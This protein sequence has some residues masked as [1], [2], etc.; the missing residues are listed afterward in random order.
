MSI[1]VAGR[2]ALAAGIEACLSAEGLPVGRLADADLASE[3]ALR[4]RLDGISVL[5]LAEDDDAGNVDLGLQARRLKPGLGVVARIFDP[6]LAAY[7]GDSVP[8]VTVLSMSAIAAPQFAESAERA[9]A[10][11]G[12]PPATLNTMPGRRGPRF[13][14]DRIL[15]FALLALFLL[16]FPSALF[17]SRALDLRYMDALYFVWTTVMTVGYGDIALKDAGDGVKL[18]GMALMLAGAAFIAILF[19]LL[20]DWVLSRRLDLLRGRTPERGANHLLIAGAGNIG[21]RLVTLLAARGRRMVVLER[22]PQG[23]NA[24]QLA[25]AG[26]HVIIGDATSDEILALAG[27]PSAA[28]LLAVTDSDAVN[29]Q[30]AL[31]ARACGVPVIMRTNSAELAAHV[32]RRGDAVALSPVTVAVERFAAAARAS[33]YSTQTERRTI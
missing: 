33:G 29:L 7:V 10:Q 5:V 8:G 30:L 15:A 20:S 9:L 1:L 2:G 28:L 17:F 31:R 25:A 11:R 6:A 4:R 26:H 32:T 27:L 18:Y 19:A 16:V 12:T 21:F 24:A 3:A 22:N 14:V 23:H 13:K